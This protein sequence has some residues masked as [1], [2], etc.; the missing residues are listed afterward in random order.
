MSSG[1]AD[2]RASAPEW[3]RLELATRRLLKEHKTYRRRAEKAERRVRDL[4]GALEGV[5]QGSIDPVALQTRLRSTQSENRML[6]ERLQEAEER[7]R[8]ILSR[9][10]FVEEDR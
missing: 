4:E 2:G 7:V 5:S 1:A 10:E 3:D 6:R 8:R 9:L